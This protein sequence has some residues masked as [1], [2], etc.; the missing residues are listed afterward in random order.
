MVYTR[1]ETAELLKIGLRTLDKLIQKREL[2]YYR[3]GRQI[4]IPYESIEEFLEA[5]RINF[6]GQTEAEIIRP[7]LRQ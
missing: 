2:A 4:R 7:V 1:K 5:N 3:I 6:E